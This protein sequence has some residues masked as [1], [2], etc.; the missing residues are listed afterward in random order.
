MPVTNEKTD[1]I[2]VTDTL[3]QKATSRKE[4]L[5]ALIISRPQINVY[6]DCTETQVLFGSMGDSVLLVSNDFLEFDAFHQDPKVSIDFHF[7]ALELYTAPSHRDSLKRC[8]WID[9][10]VM[11]GNKKELDGI[12]KGNL[13]VILTCDSCLFH[14]H[15]LFKKP[16]F[17]VVESFQHESHT[18][19]KFSDV[20]F[21][22]K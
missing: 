21:I 15:F 13:N 19:Y 16:G 8:F 11:S 18:L 3:W 5:V 4:Y 6:D 17:F 22:N 14:Y 1:E 9:E 12:R 10:E 20:N 2:I 7:N